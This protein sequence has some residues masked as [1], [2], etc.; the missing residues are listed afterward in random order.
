M[1]FGEL[2]CNFGN[3]HKANFRSTSGYHKSSQLFHLG[4]MEVKFP[5]LNSLRPQFRKRKCVYVLHKTSH[6]SISRPSRTGTAT[7]VQS[8][9]FGYEAY[10]FY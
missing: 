3:F 9:C 5:E 6:Q 1:I 4:Q 2:Q 8:C 10:C 7:H